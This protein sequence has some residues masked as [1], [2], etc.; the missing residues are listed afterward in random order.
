M[1][2]LWMRGNQESTYHIQRHMFQIRLS[3]YNGSMTGDQGRRQ[4][5]GY[6]PLPPNPWN[7]CFHHLPTLLRTCS[8]Y[9]SICLPWQF[10]S[11]SSYPIQDLRRRYSTA[12]SPPLRKQPY[13]ARTDTATSSAPSPSCSGDTP[14]EVFTRS[15]QRGSDLVH[16]RQATEPSNDQPTS[17]RSIPACQP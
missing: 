1:D 3:G 14:L 10:T 2:F 6:E 5:R 17:Y 9:L 7:L 8:I 12:F 15:Q 13:P 16:C 4:Q 11:P